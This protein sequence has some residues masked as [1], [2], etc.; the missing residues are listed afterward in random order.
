M[1]GAAEPADVIGRQAEALTLTQAEPGAT[2]GQRLVP[3]GQL[4]A[5]VLDALTRPWDDAAAFG[6]R[7]LHRLEAA[8][9]PWNEAVE[10]GRQHAA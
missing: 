10:R 3:L 2:V 5:H 6:L 4:A 7:C 8:R 1:H 9:V